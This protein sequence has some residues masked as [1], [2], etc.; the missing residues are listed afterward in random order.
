LSVVRK[1]NS[2]G[3]SI[4]RC[5]HGLTI[6]N[7]G[8]SVAGAPERKVGPTIWCSP[9]GGRLRPTVAFNAMLDGSRLAFKIPAPSRS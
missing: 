4:G 8:S 1:Q 6:V 3:V 7:C 9:A 2:E 5:Y